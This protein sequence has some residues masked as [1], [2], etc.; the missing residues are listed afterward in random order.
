MQHQLDFDFLW[1]K[2]NEQCNINNRLF[3]CDKKTLKNAT[4][5][6]DFFV[7]CYMRKTEAHNNQ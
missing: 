6:I 2:I 3:Q 1:Y 7:Q 4:S 5:V